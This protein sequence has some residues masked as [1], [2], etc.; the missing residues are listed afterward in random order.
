MELKAEN[1]VHQNGCPDVCEVPCGDDTVKELSTSTHLHDKIDDPVILK[2]F[3]E[4]DDVWWHYF[5][6]RL[7][8]CS[9]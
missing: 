9:R 2:R 5:V 3:A 7:I 1:V 6:R 8:C 4:L